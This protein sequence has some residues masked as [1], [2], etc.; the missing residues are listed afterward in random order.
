MSVVDGQLANA[1]T[2]NSAFGSKQSNNTFTGVQTLSNSES[3]SSISNVQQLLNNHSSTIS[4]NTTNINNHISDT[5]NPHNVTKIQVGLGLCDNTP[6]LNKPISIATQAALD[7]K[8]SVDESIINS[9]I[10][11]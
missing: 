9:L 2:F 4:T 6:D 11:G 7:N 3:G 5:L 1:S 8:A 10:F